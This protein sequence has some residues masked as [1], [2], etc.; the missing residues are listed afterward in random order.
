MR[1]CW[2]SANTLDVTV[3]TKLLVFD[4]ATVARTNSE[5]FAKKST[6]SNVITDDIVDDGPMAA[7]SIVPTLDAV[8]TRAGVVGSTASWANA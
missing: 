8:M 2:I 1:T 6:S 3:S 5:G 7:E 4:T